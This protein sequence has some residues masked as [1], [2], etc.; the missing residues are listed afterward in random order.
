MCRGA[1]QAVVQL[2]SIA[3]AESPPSLLPL[4]LSG[5]G[6]RLPPLA[7]AKPTNHWH[8]SNGKDPPSGHHVPGLGPIVAVCQSQCALEAAP[9][10]ASPT[11]S[12]AIPGSMITIPHFLFL[13]TTLSLFKRSYPSVCIYPQFISEGPARDF[14]FRSHVADYEAYLTKDR[15]SI[16]DSAAVSPRLTRKKGC[17]FI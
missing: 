11:P 13:I 16:S 12:T 2:P 4:I 14:A 7:F 10:P 8:H 15:L 17:D 6:S 3:P 1:H 9:R 5:L